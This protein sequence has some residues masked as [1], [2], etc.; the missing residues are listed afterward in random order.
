M[1]YR[2]VTIVLD[3]YK[4]FNEILVNVPNNK[5][6]D[7]SMD[8]VNVLPQ[9]VSL[10]LGCEDNLPITFVVMFSLFLKHVICGLWCCIIY[11]KLRKLKI[12]HISLWTAN[13]AISLLPLIFYSS[14][15][16]MCFETSNTKNLS[17]LMG[18][19]FGLSRWYM[20][21]R[22]LVEHELGMCICWCDI[23]PLFCTSICDFFCYHF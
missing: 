6:W 20:I 13:K 5:Q 23:A 15:S 18:N 7:P 22:Y 12:T 4:I 8:C 19:N 16:Y 2:S 21:L 9:H 1:V 17:W 10:I 14:K 11:Q 3:I